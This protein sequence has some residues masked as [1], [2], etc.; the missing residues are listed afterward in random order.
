MTEADQGLGGG[1]EEGSV[2]PNNGLSKQINELVGA[3]GILGFEETEKDPLCDHLIPLP[4][5]EDHVSIWA[6]CL[7]DH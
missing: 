7:Q 4:G 1:D 5:E 6:D 3:A 2:E